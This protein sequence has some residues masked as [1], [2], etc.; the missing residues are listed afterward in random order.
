MVKKVAVFLTANFETVEALAPIDLM[1][2]AGIEVTTISLD[3]TLS[4][5]S[6]QQVTV[7][8]DKM[9]K[10]VQVQEF[11]AL[12]LPGGG[13]D[14]SKYFAQAETI[15]FFAQDKNKVLAAICMAPTVLARLDLLTGKQGTCYPAM[16]EHFTAHQVEFKATNAVYLDEEKILLGR[17]C[18]A[19]F[20]FGLKL[21]EVVTDKATA[22][23]VAEAIVYQ[24]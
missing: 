20:D 2:R 8:A 22:Q 13:L 14:E 3:Q 9:P 10:Q 4:V 11:D 6:H 23:R 12:F 1:R 17:A 15:K 7:Q 21:V 18:G 24:S 5:T 16:Q 19:A